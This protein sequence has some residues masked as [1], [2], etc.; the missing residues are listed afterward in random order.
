MYGICSRSACRPP[1]TQSS[2]K[3][4]KHI[5]LKLSWFNA[6]EIKLGHSMWVE[7]AT[8]QPGQPQVQHGNFKCNKWTRS[9]S[10][11][12]QCLCPKKQTINVQHLS[13]TKMMCG[14]WPAFVTHELWH[15]LTIYSFVGWVYLFRYLPPNSELPNLMCSM[16]CAYACQCTVVPLSHKPLI[17]SCA[18]C[19]RLARDRS[20]IHMDP[21]PR[22]QSERHICQHKSDP[23]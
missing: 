16:Q 18:K 23:L 3:H 14:T 21:R 20:P 8:L 19:G 13:W 11:V 6:F 2:C 7:T 17:R 5:K 4:H 10:S 12:L 15:I 1:I 9:V 22:V